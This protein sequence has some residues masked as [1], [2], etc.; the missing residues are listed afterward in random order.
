MKIKTA[1][2]LLFVTVAIAA[3]CTT[4]PTPAFDSATVAAFDKIMSDMKTYASAEGFVLLVSVPGKGD[5]LGVKGTDEVATGS[6]IDPRKLFRAGSIT[7]T[8]TNTVT[9]QLVDEGLISLE[10]TVDKYLTGIP[11][12]D[13]ITIKMLL[14]HTSGLPNYTASSAF[15]TAIAADRFHKYTPQDLL[16]FA[17]ALP[18]TAAPGTEYHYSNTNTTILGMIIE[19]YN[20][21]GETL[22]Q[23]VKRRVID[24]IG[25][26]NTTFATVET[27]PGAYLHG[28]MP[29][30][31]TGTPEDWSLEDPSWMWAAGAVISNIY[32]LKAYIKAIYDNSAGLLSP[33]MQAKRINDDWVSI[34]AE[35]PTCKYGLGWVQIGGFFCHDGAVPGYHCI[36]AYDP[37]TGTTVVAMM[38]TEPNDISTAMATLL[39]VIKQLYPTRAL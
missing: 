34:S 18:M 20:A 2:A 4:S 5:Y 39:M 31:A 36:A 10:A 16:N 38:N 37:A 22:A 11:S 35:L 26:I 17:F 1:F 9:L 14:N 27:F 7:K 3:G 30:P 32:D 6:A 24:K 33:A 13:V 12:G 8:F 15:W 21:Q 29:N 19:K 23:A 25:L 28:Y